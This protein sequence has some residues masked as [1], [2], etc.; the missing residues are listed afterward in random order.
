MAWDKLEDQKINCMC[1]TIWR[2]Q[3]FINLSNTWILCNIFYPSLPSI[4]VTSEHFA[5]QWRLFPV[6][7]HVEC[8]G[9]NDNLLLMS[10]FFVCLITISSQDR[11]SITLKPIPSVRELKFTRV[12]ASISLFGS[13]S[14]GNPLD[15]DLVTMNLALWTFENFE[16]HST[17]H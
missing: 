12:H 10:H 8:K 4:T 13:E 5:S 14:G 3:F 9:S 16:D 1:P 6:I 11:E 17:G 7:E 2:I 15:S